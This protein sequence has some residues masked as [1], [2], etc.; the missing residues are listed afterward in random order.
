MASYREHIYMTSGHI[1]AD[2]G[3]DPG[4]ALLYFNKTPESLP[5]KLQRRSVSSC[6]ELWDRMRLVPTLSCFLSRPSSSCFLFPLAPAIL[7]LFFVFLSFHSSWLKN[8]AGREDNYSPPPLRCFT[9][10]NETCLSL[11][12][13]MSEELQP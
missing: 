8:Q 4:S 5:V 9:F 10:G 3:P 11:S 6:W 12:A 7:V 2:P 13:L 1:R